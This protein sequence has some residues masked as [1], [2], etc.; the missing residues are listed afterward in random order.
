MIDHFVIS[1]FNRKE[2][3]ETDFEHTSLGFQ[4]KKSAFPKWVGKFRDVELMIDRAM[5]LHIQQ[6]LTALER[7]QP[8]LFEKAY[9]IFP[10]RC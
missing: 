3:L 9:G 6:L 2:L 7:K 1:C 5:H 8:P 4:L 10:T